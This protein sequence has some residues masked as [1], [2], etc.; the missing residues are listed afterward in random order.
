M[1]T[2]LRPHEP[3]PMLLSAPDFVCLT[4][5]IKRLQPIPTR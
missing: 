3:E 1:A 2:K 4:M 5:D